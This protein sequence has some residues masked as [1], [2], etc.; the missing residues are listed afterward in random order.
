MKLKIFLATILTLVFV[1]SPFVVCKIYG[2]SACD[3]YID[4]L[5]I[6]MVTM[7]GFLLFLGMLNSIFELLND[8]NETY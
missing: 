1:L 7:V 4:W 2:Y 5:I 3:Q 8:D 6:I